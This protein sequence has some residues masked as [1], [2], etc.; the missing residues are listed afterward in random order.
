M[1]EDAK[2][3][4][5]NLKAKGNEHFKRGE[6]REAINCYTSA[7]EIDPKNAVLLSNRAFANFKIVR[8]IILYNRLENSLPYL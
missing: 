7:L 1:E 6:Y 3:K 8:L 5:E 2:T 4:V